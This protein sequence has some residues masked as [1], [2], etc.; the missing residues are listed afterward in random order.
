MF[1]KK[2]NLMLKN[3][4]RFRYN[5]HYVCRA[6]LDS[7]NDIDNKLGALQ[8]RVDEAI[9]MLD[10]QDLEANHKKQLSKFL[11]ITYPNA[12]GALED[13]RKTILNK[14][15]YMPKPLTYN[16]KL[17]LIALIVTVVVTLVGVS[18][19]LIIDKY[20]QKESSLN[21]MVYV[22]RTKKT[23]HFDDYCIK[24]SSLDKK[25]KVSLRVALEEEY[26]PCRICSEE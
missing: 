8:L 16:G 23:Y 4:K 10:N 18:A 11:N 2:D 5:D 21:R 14:Y 19:A 7:L 24:L 13:K 25:E 26:T 22:S 1:C 15:K 6:D 17:R 20:N 9:K 3:E 12:K